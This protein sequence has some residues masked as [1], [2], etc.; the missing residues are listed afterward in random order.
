[1]SVKILFIVPYPHDTAP[2]QRLKFEQYYK[3]FE[4]AGYEITTASFIGRQ[5]WQFIYKKGFYFKKA[6]YTLTGYFKRYAL[7][8]SVNKYDI[9]YIH[10]WATPFGLPVTEWVLCRLSKKLIY[11][12]D[13]LIYKGDASPNNKFISFFKT[14]AKINFLMKHADHVLVSTEKLLQYTL[15]LTTRVSL[16][17][18]TIDVEKYKRV[19]VKKYD[20]VVIGWSGSHTTSKYLHLLDNVLKTLADKYP[21]TISVMGDKDFEIPG[22]KVELVEWSAATEIESLKQFDIGLHPMPDEE[23]VYGKSG[24]KLVQYLA[25]GIPIVAS[26]IGPNFIVIKEGYNGFLASNDEEWIAKLK[27][28]ITNEALRKEMGK[29]AVTCAGQL[30]SVEANLNK[31]LAVFNSK[32]N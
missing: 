28:L 31:Y 24:G 32:E 4:E 16:I 5:F 11:D 27:L 21:I 22:L 2:S 17:P 26:A 20:G 6:V 25:A 15:N 8:A 13:D 10:L 29:N 7:L 30:Y 1:M 19:N 3:S 18:A 23:W 14:S 9:V 12:I